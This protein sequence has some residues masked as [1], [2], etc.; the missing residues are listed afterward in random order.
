MGSDYRTLTFVSA[1][2]IESAVQYRSS[3]L[4]YSYR[5]AYGRPATAKRWGGGTP[6]SDGAIVA[7]VGRAQS[8]EQH[9]T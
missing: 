3:R 7:Y 1:T 2:C 5:P 8:V 6:A 9:Y 4:A